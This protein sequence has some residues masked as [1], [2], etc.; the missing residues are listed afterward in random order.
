MRLRAQNPPHI[1][2]RESNQTVMIDVI[3]ALLPLYAMATY[4]YGTRAIAL[5]LFG[6]AVAQITD[7]IC[8]AIS[9]RVP[10]IRDL[11][12][13]VTGLLIPLMMPATARFAVIGIS[14][15]FAICVVKYPFGGT[16]HNIFNPAVAGAAFALVCWPQTFFMYPTP[17]EKLPMMIADG[18][19]KLVNSPAYVLKLGGMPTTEL[20]DMLLGNFAGPMGATNILVLLTCLLFLTVRKSVSFLPTAAFVSGAALVAYFFPRADMTPINSVCYELMC[21]TLMLGAV[22]L[23]SD[24]VTSPKRR[25]PK[26][27]YCF[28]A[29]AVSLLFRH[30]GSFEESLLFAI[31]IMNSVV[32]FADLWGEQLAHL[33]RRKN[34]E[35]KRNSQIQEQS[36][37]DI[38]AAQE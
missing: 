36:D 38:G 11:S 26:I 37:E 32:W 9:R 25:I 14:A 4:Y 20:L 29:G 2:M 5:G 3:I 8:C 24:P 31:L 22:F 15:V 1:R 19:V 30:L 6:A 12:A 34:V 28:L 21:G 35:L 33:V 17:F 7:V 18:A 13:V 10:N 23:I 16:G 27:I